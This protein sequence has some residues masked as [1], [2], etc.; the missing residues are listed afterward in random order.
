VT[1]PTVTDQRA[2]RTLPTGTVTFMRTDVEGSM[3]LV[4]AL[5]PAWDEVNAMHMDIVRRAIDRRRGATVRTEGDAI[6]AVFPEARAAVAAAI[7]I[8]RSIEDHV[9]PDAHSM[10]VRIGL[11]SGEAYL[12]GDDYGG[13]EVNRAARIAASGHG[14][15]IVLSEPTRALVA[16]AL[17]DGVRLRDLGHHALRDLP[18]REVIY[19]LDVPGL[20]TIFP[21]LRTIESAIGNLP[22][23]MTS[24]IGRD[25]EMEALDGLLAKHRLI[26]L[27]G[28]GGIGKTSIAIEL[29][30][31]KANDFRDGAWL[32]ELDDLK[33]TAHVRGAIA[34]TLGLFDGTDR[35]ATESLGP[36]IAERSLLLVLDNFEH[37]LGAA[38]EVVTI[39]RSSPA[40]KVIVASR[41]PLRVTGEQEFPVQP[42]AAER[43]DDPSIRLFTDRARMVR[44]AYDSQADAT[45]V[46]ETCRLL[47][48]LPLGIELAAARVSLL[49]VATIRDRL[50][51]RLPLPGPDL[52]GV[53]D[54]QRTLDGAIA[55]SYDLLTSERQRLL[56]DLAV[57][58]GGFDLQQVE[59]IHEG[60]DVLEAIAQLVDQSLVSPDVDGA[61]ELRFRLLKTIEAFALRE[62]RAEG[63]EDDV[64]RRHALAYLAL[65]EASTNDLPGALQRGIL[66]RLRL[67]HANLRGAVRWAID[68]EDVEIALRSV[69]ALWRY[70]QLDGHL[71]EGH[72]LTDE[73]L[74]MTGADAPT[75][76]R[77]RAVTAAGGIAYW[78]GR[79]EDAVRWYNEQLE[80]ARDLG[81]RAGEADACFNGIWRHFI[82]RDFDRSVAMMEA[83]RRIYE[84]LGDD[85]GLDRLEWVRG[86]ILMNQGR[87]VEARQ[88]FESALHRYVDSGDSW[89]EALALGSLAWN[90]YAL[91]DPRQAVDSYVRSM[92]LGYS[93]G[94]MAT[95]SISLE[96]AA[97]GALEL[98]EPEAAATLL[99]ALEAAVIQYGVRP[100]AGLALLISTKAPQERVRDE[101]DEATIAAAMERGRRMSLDE[102][103]DLF[104]ATARKAGLGPS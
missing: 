33:D 103:V 100:P 27:T 80:L 81:D 26:T 48:G 96:V 28:P 74:A 91:G 62:L 51:A 95:T 32:V 86:T 54:R 21:R 20:R 101:L 78:Q 17:P 40:S 79:P 65:A 99:G 15:Q 42:L 84:E 23:R 68:H 59:V 30:R 70:W 44:P 73:A 83:A 16:D 3:A 67:D 41:A 104:V 75:A 45:A 94:D 46:E 25:D 63:R 37:L 31:T 76:A 2:S 49:P 39:L 61:F 77:L 5:G 47:D 57:F 34:R 71:E 18:R 55:W 56:R 38:S 35:A 89:Y 43:S 8:Q 29:A 60:Q 12:A 13:F 6:F 72:A 64:R 10:H 93:L 102:A 85:R 1:Q 82:T 98:G 88:A 52:R 22:E 66:Q 92:I 50:A 87:Q 97:I 24:F 69:G 19:Q 7:E 11:H 90:S 58:D 14:G 9:W 36:Y 53:P 4:R